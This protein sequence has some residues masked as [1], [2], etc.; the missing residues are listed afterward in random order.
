MKKVFTWILLLI[1]II[2]LIACTPVSSEETI[3]YTVTFD[4]VGGSEV[5]T[6]TIEKGKTATKPTH[7]T[8]EG[9]D[10]VYWFMDDFNVE[11]DFNTP[12]TDNITLYAKWYSQMEFL[13]GI[14]PRNDVYYQIFVRSFADSDGDGVGD[15]NGITLNLDYLESLG[16]SAIW[17]LPVNTTDLDW[18]SY[19]GYRIKDYYEVNPEYGTMEDFENLIEEASKRDIKIVMDLVINHTSDTHPWFLDAQSSVNSQYRDYYIW[20]TPTSAF[21]SFAGGMVDLNLSNPT[22]VQEVKDIMQYWLEKGIHG[23]R[24]DAAKHFFLKPGVTAPDTQAII[25]LA[26]INAFVKS[27]NPDS[28]LIAEIF[29]YVYQNYDDYFAPID[30]LFDFYGANEIWSKVGAQSSR[31]FLSRNLEKAYNAY[32]NFN[33]NFVVAP[34]I[35][36]HDIDRVASLGEFAGINHTAKLKQAASVYLTLPG[37]PHVYYGEEIGMKGTKYE[38]INPTGQGTIWDQYRRAPF[39]WG[40]ETYQTTWLLPYNGSDDAISV[41]DQLADPNSLLNHY[42]TIINIR[43]QN[44]ALMYGNYFKEWRA[45]NTNIQSYIRYYEYGDIKQAVLVIHNLADVSASVEVE[46]V[47]FIY[48]DSLQ[49]KP[50]GTIILELNPALLS[51]YVD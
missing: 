7:P 45:Q 48:G 38:G 2:T 26:G 18:D 12:I 17:M 30:S 39:I 22:V 42:K 46:F 8:K 41:K 16:I 35:S 5:Q 40:E 15:F 32:R 44:P 4:S 43:R 24:F 33:Q 27:I 49:L 23:F 51:Q 47:K 50:F 3:Y 37:S 11:F 34:F 14:N 21:R 29:D 1:S 20:T 9:Y 36:N 6:Q 31:Q 13:D 28:Y 19:H 25:F 10:F